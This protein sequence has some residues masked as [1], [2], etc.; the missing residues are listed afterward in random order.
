M[1]AFGRALLGAWDLD[2]SVVYLNHGTVGAVP[3]RVLAKAERIRRDVE[4]QPSRYLLRELAAIRVGGPRAEA[5]R[6]RRAADLVGAFLGVDGGDLAFVDNATTGINAVLRSL[7]FREGDEILLFDHGYGAIALA[8]SY[9]ARERGASVRAVAVP[10][11]PFDPAALL[12]GLAAALTPR[13]RLAILD[14]VTSESA[15]LLPIHEMTAICRERGVPVLVDGAHAP[16]AIN[17]DI[18]AIGA[19]WYAGNLHKWAWSPRSCGVLWAAPDRQAGIHPPVISWGLDQGFTTEFDWVGTRDPAPFLAAPEGIA[20]M[21]EMGVDAV[22]RYTHGLARGAARLLASRW[23]T[24]VPA[25]ESAIATMATVPLP[26]RAGRAPE[27]ATRLRDA[28]L[29]EDRIEAQI[30][31]WR[32]RLWVRI[33]AQVYNETGDY[34]RLADAVAGRI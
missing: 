29:E 21:R 3:R 22:H 19:D 10:Y 32:E 31:A 28:L 25:P 15:L 5:P 30:H 18:D 20:M 11:P 13:T 1:S 23:G 26:E 34:E 27:D 8:A 6:L 16:G 33:S 4:R 2:P 24:S 14:H 9:V 17:L 12:D 7:P